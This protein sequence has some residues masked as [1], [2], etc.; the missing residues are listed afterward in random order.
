M[1]SGAAEV[2]AGSLSEVGAAAFTSNCPVDEIEG[3]VALVVRLDEPSKDAIV[4]P[5]TSRMGKQA[6][7]NYE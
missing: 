3:V 1:L 2:E 7:I 5:F 4:P 6:S